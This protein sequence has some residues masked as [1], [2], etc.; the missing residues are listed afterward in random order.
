MAQISIKV[1]L[2]KYTMQALKPEAKTFALTEWYR[3]MFDY[4]PFRTGTL[5]SLQEF[6]GNYSPAEAMAI[7]MQQIESDK[8]FI[9]FTAKYA[10]RMYYGEDFNF[11]KDQHPLAQALWG[12]VAFE[13]HGE[14]IINAI[15][16]YIIMKGQSE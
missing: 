7:G 8:L 10:Q 3:Y 12:D 13:L 1:P 11:S 5:A 4:I 9:R 14:Q 15:K 16:K 2:D 6:E